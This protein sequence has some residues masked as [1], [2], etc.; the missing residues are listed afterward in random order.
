MLI[1]V[2]IAKKSTINILFMKPFTENFISKGSVFT[3]VFKNSLGE[4]TTRDFF[5][6]VFFGMQRIDNLL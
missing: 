4:D 5:Y 2:K 3:D 1:L 6:K